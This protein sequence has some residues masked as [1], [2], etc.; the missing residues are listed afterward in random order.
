VSSATVAS[1]ARHTQW[2][3]TD[4]VPSLRG[5]LLPYV[6]LLARP[7]LSRR[8]QVSVT[9]MEHVPLRGPLLFA[10]NHVGIL[11]GPLL[12]AY[13]P[14]PVHALVKREMFDRRLGPV[15]RTLGQIP[16][17]RDTVD[18]RA[19]KLMLRVL[20]D[21]G[22][23][24]IYPEGARGT[25]DFAHSRLGAA[26]LALCTGVPVVPVACLGTRLP[27]ASVSAVPPHGSRVDLVYGAAWNVEPVAWPRRKSHVAA[28]AE[29]LRT[30]LAAHV[31]AA[32]AATGQDLPGPAPDEV[33]DVAGR[34]GPE[35][36]PAATEIAD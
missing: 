34:R 10:S 18:P 11:D 1:A 25:G 20:R 36:G 27:G 16:V 33:K 13:A 4:A 23:V 8:Y 5:A 29:E 7:Y 28:V 3:R 35:V 22:V 15:L 12:A 17:R 26:Y 31:R 21:D 30:Y 19:V 6:G 24:A 14:R 32:C 9:G 2:P